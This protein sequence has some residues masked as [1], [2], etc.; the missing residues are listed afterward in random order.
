MQG[1]NARGLQATDS[2]SL[3][4]CRTLDAGG[5]WLSVYG[6]W[7]C[8]CV[9]TCTFKGSNRGSSLS[10]CIRPVL[11]YNLPPYC[12]PFLGLVSGGSDPSFHSTSGPRLTS[13]SL[14]LC[15]LRF[16]T[17]WRSQSGQGGG[18]ICTVCSHVAMLLS[19]LRDRPQRCSLSSLMLTPTFSLRCG[20]VVCG[21]NDPWIHNLRDRVPCTI[22]ALDDT[23]ERIE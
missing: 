17:R 8:V 9:V 4:T 6:V 1:R 7:C 3:S 15:P 22:F 19:Q 2:V 5:L 23:H 18:G 10:P 21:V 14:H 16:C 13:C 12:V 20:L 11:H